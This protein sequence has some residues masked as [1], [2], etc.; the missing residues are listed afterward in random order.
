M[1][2]FM[3]FENRLAAL[4]IVLPT[5]P[6]PVAAY[7]PTV[8]SSGHLFVSGQLPMRGGKVAITGKL[9]AD[10]EVEQGKEAAQLC[11][12]NILAQ[13]R[14]ALGSL[15][16][17][18]RCVRLGVFVAGTADFT[19]QPQIA[20]GASDLM[21]EIFGEAGKHARAAVGVPSLPLNAAVEIEALFEVV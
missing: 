14:A 21:V 16:K 6:A 9:G 11:A 10:V 18:K 13:V 4:G 1:G 12:I 17:V 2:L 8:L 19:A 3:S 5:P 20:N 7:V 15:D